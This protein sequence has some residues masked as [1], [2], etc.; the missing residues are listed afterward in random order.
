LNLDGSDH[1]WGKAMTFA[2]RLRE[3]RQ[4]AGL[5]EAKLA[6]AAGVPFD[7]VHGYGLGRRT[8]S[9][10]AVLQLA[11]ALGVDCTAFAGCT[12]GPPPK[13]TRRPGRP[14]K[15]A[16]RTPAKRQRSKEKAGPASVRS[17]AGP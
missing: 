13:G 11:A 2:E 14:P 9:F 6:R 12:F 5:S 16:A 15:G 8:P 17:P 10:P 7:T 1:L 4:A 3:L